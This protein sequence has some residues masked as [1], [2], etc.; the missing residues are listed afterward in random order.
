FHTIP[1]H[2]IPFHTIPCHTHAH[3]I[4]MRI[5]PIPPIAIL[6]QHAMNGE[7]RL[8]NVTTD[9]ITRKH[10]E[11][12]RAVIASTG[13]DVVNKRMKLQIQYLST[14]E[15]KC[16]RWRCISTPDPRFFAYTCM[17][18]YLYSKFQKR[19]EKKRKEK[20]RKEKKRKEKKKKKK[21][22]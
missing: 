13:D 5:P 2:S 22:K 1:Y 21:K 19:K 16:K 3:S 15:Q 14:K 18:M 8:M 4:T 20:K 12:N 10:C 11:F 7:I 6:K 17:H 9:A